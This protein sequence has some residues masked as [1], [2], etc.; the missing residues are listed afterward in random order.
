MNLWDS[1]RDELSNYPVREIG[2]TE[3]STKKRSL[4]AHLPCKEESQR[5]NLPRRSEKCYGKIDS[6]ELL[7]KQHP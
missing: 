2:A 5:N 1:K 7:R 3:L 4:T 6:Y